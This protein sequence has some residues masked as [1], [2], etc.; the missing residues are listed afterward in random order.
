MVS[1]KQKSPSGAGLQMAGADC[2]VAFTVMALMRFFPNSGIHFTLSMAAMAS[3]RK[4]STLANHWSVARKMV[5]FL[6]RQS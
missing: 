4:L 2:T 3:S 5:G 1:A 6:V